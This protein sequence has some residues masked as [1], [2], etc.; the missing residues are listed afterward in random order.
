MEVPWRRRA[1]AIQSLTR[2]LTPMMHSR[3]ASRRMACGEWRVASS[4]PRLTVHCER[5]ALGAQGMAAA[6]AVVTGEPFSQPAP[7]GRYTLESGAASGAVGTA[8]TEEA[9]MT[10][11]SV[12]DAR[13]RWGLEG[14]E[15]SVPDS[16]PLVSPWLDR[17]DPPISRLRFCTE[18]PLL[19]SR[20]VFELSVSGLALCAEASEWRVTWERVAD[21]PSCCKEGGRDDDV[22][23]AAERSVLMPAVLVP[24]LPVIS[25]KRSMNRSR[26]SAFLPSC[27]KMASISS[28]V[29]M[30]PRQVSRSSRVT[31]PSAFKSS[32]LNTLRTVG[33]SSPA[34]EP[35]GRE[36][37][38]VAARN[39][40]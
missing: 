2:Q 39:S 8:G 1:S 5:Y 40:L 32:M 37:P 34:S 9:A 11:P 38:S 15:R 10:A 22:C 28:S 4:I 3:V 20:A 25:R 6:H 21:L 16:A 19:W 36:P 24:S 30:P 35:P 18:R 27:A 23:D 14:L 26:P 31:T 13:G 29:T 12:L 7:V 17:F 33:S